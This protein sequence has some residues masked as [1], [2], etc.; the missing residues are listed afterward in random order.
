VAE[1][2]VI[3]EASDVQPDKNDTCFAYVRL[4]NGPECVEHGS[5][6]REHLRE[7][8]EGL[9]NDAAAADGVTEEVQP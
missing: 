7:K 5:I 9:P 2:H 1:G 4:F 6:E 8:A 3:G